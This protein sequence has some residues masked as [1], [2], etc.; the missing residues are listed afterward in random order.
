MRAGK[1]TAKPLHL[2]HAL[3]HLRKRLARHACWR[4]RLGKTQQQHTSASDMLAV[5]ATTR[6]CLQPSPEGSRIRQ[7]ELRLCRTTWHNPEATRTV[8]LQKRP[9]QIL[10]PHA[11]F[12][13]WFVVV[14]GVRSVRQ[15]AAAH[16]RGAEHGGM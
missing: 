12:P 3:G 15:T 16:R 10:V 11:S 8:K 1:H 7:R 6:R 9:S 2:G 4:F 14:Y 5:A 13:S